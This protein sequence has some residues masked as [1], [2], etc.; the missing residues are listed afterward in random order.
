MSPTTPKGASALTT[1][2]KRPIV[3]LQ[4]K[5]GADFTEN[6]N[7]LL[8]LIASVPTRSVVVTPEVGLTGFAYDRMEEAVDVSLRYRD[9]ILQ[10][11]DDKI[12]TLTYIAKEDSGYYNRTDVLYDGRVVHSQDKVKLFLPG[13][14]GR[15]FKPGDPDKIRLF[16]IEGICMGLLVCFELRFVEY[17]LR[18][19]GADIVLNPSRW[20]LPRKDHY[21]VFTRALAL[22]NQCYVAASNSADEDMAASSGVVGPDGKVLSDDDAKII[23]G[24]YSPKEIKKMRR[25]IPMGV[26]PAENERVCG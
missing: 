8:E 25:Y 26:I 13:D 10:R 11:F 2:D 14:E 3:V 9:E 1:S 22:A 15:Y 24:V 20:G 21:E 23:E 12:V 17:W 16:E 7:H 6:G 18:F 4:T 5:T 19:R